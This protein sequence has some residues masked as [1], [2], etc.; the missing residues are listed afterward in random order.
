MYLLTAIINNEELLDDLITGWL[1]IGITGAT[2]VES[3]DSLQ[4]IS[5]HVPIFAGFRALT[6]G[7]V[8]HN[9]T[10]FTVI[11]DQQVL[12]AAIGFLKS[13]C[14]ETGKPHQGVY[15]VTPITQFGRLGQEVDATQHKRHVKKKIE[16]R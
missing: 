8:R 5:H 14:R 2:L 12:D 6:S 4:L 10:I 15:F 16:G 11:E 7:G 13:I 3:T 9:K 1:D